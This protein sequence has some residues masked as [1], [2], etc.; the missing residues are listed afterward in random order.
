MHCLLNLKN[1]S[2]GNVA[3]LCTQLLLI[4]SMSGSLDP[5]CETDVWVKIFL[6]LKLQLHRAAYFRTWTVIL[7]WGRLWELFVLFLMFKLGA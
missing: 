2:V 1:N 6:E 3:A 7:G 5:C 4:T